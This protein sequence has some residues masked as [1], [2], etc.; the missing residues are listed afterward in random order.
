MSNR[1]PAPACVFVLPP[2]PTRLGPIEKPLAAKVP[3]LAE[4]PALGQMPHVPHRRGEAI[5]ERRHVDDFRVAAGVVHR[6][7]FAGVQ[8]QRLL[9]HHVLAVP[10]G[11]E[12]D[13]FVRE[14]RR[15]DDDRIDVRIG[16]D[17]LEV[18]RDIF[19]A[20]VLA[21]LLE[22]LRAGVA[23]AGQPGPRIEAN[24]RHMVIIAD[25]AGSDDGDANGVRRRSDVGMDGGREECR[26]EVKR[27]YSL[28]AGGSVAN[29]QPDCQR[30]RARE[31][32]VN[33]KS[34]NSRLGSQVRVC[35]YSRRKRLA[36]KRFTHDDH[37]A[38]R[39]ADRFSTARRNRILRP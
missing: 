17:R 36:A 14:I 32:A 35:R 19:A 29:R 1:S 7:H 33:R 30:G 6:P 27:P 15:G 2:A 28:M 39:A 9:A 12:R 11:G 25:R 26:T 20:P 34:R 31:F 38:V 5:R 37:V 13:R 24:R 21:A 18:G 16:A 3:Q 10:G 22:Q 8:P 4:R 23:D